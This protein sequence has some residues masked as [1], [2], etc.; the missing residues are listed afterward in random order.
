M[1]TLK[2]ENFTPQKKLVQNSE[3]FKNCQKHLEITYLSKDNYQEKIYKLKKIKD[4]KFSSVHILGG[5][6]SGENK[7]CITNSF[8]KVQGLKNLYINDSS[9][10]NSKLLKN[11][12]GMVMS[13]AKNNIDNFIKNSR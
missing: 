7:N 6:T 4:Y 5:I 3:D 1:S 12:Q 13:I 9:L 2:W 11:P 8:G 10:I